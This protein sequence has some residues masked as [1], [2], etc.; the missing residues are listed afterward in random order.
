[1]AWPA[2]AGTLPAPGP[3]APPLGPPVGPPVGPPGRAAEDQE[4][5]FRQVFGRLAAGVTVV[6]TMSADG[7][8]GLTAT[9]VCSVSLDPLLVLACIHNGSRTLAA[10]EQADAFAVNILRDHQ[11]DVATAFAA[12]VPEPVRFAAAPYRLH[13]GV[14]VLDDALAWVTCGVAETYPGGDHTIV[15]GAVT[16]LSLSAGEPLVRESGRYRQ[17]QPAVRPLRPVPGSVPG[18]VPE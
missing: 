4:R 16:G 14:P 9:A 13:Y 17:L 3:L 7:P 8:S 1:M 12:P 15:L 5:L 6:T 11:A 18:S 10:L 2:V